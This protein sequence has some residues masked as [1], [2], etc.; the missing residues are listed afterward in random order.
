MRRVCDQRGTPSSLKVLRMF[1]A[2]SCDTMPY[3]KV[4]GHREIF[5]P[6][7][8]TEVFNTQQIKTSTK[9][10]KTYV[11]QKKTIFWIWYIEPFSVW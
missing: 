6:S 9:L 11:V 1:D 8:N 2:L 4:G 3:N 5:S 7:E 10:S